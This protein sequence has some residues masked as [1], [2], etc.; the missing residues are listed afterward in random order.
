MTK[1]FTKTKIL[2]KNLFKFEK[3]QKKSIPLQHQKKNRQLRAVRTIR[4]HSSV[5]LE[6][7]PYKQRVMGSTPF[8]PTTGRDRKIRSLFIYFHYSISREATT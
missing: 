5:G 8:A 4:E 6:H 1:C 7:L 2:K 3:S